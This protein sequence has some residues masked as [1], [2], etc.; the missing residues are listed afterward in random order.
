MASRTNTAILAATML[1]TLVS[2]GAWANAPDEK[3]SC[4]SFV[5]GFYD[6][7]VKA[8]GKDSKHSSLEVAMMK[9]PNDFSPLLRTKLKAD[10][11]ASAKSADGIVGLDFDPILSSQIDPEP[12]HVGRVMQNGAVYR[13]EVYSRVEGKLSKSPHV[14][15]ELKEVSGH[16]QFV[17]FHYKDDGKDEDLIS[18][19]K[20]LA[21]DRKKYGNK[22]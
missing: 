7:Y 8:T 11:D 5:Q 10:L 14:Y 17:N 12:Y 16:W 2:P 4:K 13:A 18:I 15:P 22:G 19:L 20:S 9:R 1:L 6:W 3:A 21:A